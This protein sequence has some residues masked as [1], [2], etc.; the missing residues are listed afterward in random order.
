MLTDN[1]GGQAD[2]VF[3]VDAGRPVDETGRREASELTRRI[4]AEPDL[5][6]RHVV[7]DHQGAGDAVRG[8]H[9][10]AGGGVDRR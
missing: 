1:F 4:A 10:G 2:L 5:H 8:R 7:L 6:R 9:Q 3:V